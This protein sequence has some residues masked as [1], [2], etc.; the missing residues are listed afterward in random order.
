MPVYNPPEIFL[1]EAIESVLNQSY[2]H[3]EF[4]IA[5]DASPSLHIKHILEEYQ[6]QDSRIKVIFRTQNG[7]ISATSNSALELATGEFIGLLDH[8]DVLTPD[9]LYEVV[10]LLNQNPAADMIYSDED[11]LNEKGELTGHFFKPDWCPDSFLSRMYTCHFGVYRRSIIQ[12]I[13]GFRI[14]YEGSQDYD[15]VLR[16]TEKTDKIFH[17]PKI[18][19]HWRIHN[20]SAAGGTEAKPYAYEAAK[21]ALQDAIDRRGEPGI[22]KDVSIY[23]GHYLV[24]Y[25]ILDYKRV[26]III[27][28]RD[29]GEILN[30]CLESIFTLSIYPDYEVIVIDNGSTEEETQEI[31]EKWQEKEPT[32]FRYYALDIPFN[33]SKI[34]NYAVRQAT[35]DYLLLL[36]NDTEVIH[37]DWIDAM[38][39]QAQRRS[40][41]AVG[42]L[43]R[44]PDKIVQHAGVVVGIGHF[45]AHSHRMASETDPGYYGQVISISNYSAVTAACLMC[46]REV[47]E[48]V[49]GFDEQLAVAYNDVDFCLK[50]VEQGYRNIYLP[51]VV[52]YHYESKSRGYDTTPDKL[53]RFM[54]EVTIMRQRWQHY[55]DYD[56]CYNPNLTLSSSNYG[57]RQFAEVKI[58]DVS[59]KLDDQVLEN[60]SIDEP[61]IKIYTGIS[62]I[63]FK[64]WV[65]GQQEKVTA[66][67]IIG[68]HAQV[69]K[70]IP[71]N[72]SRPDV[73]IL[74]PENP[75][76]ELCGFDETVEITNLS[77][78]TE[79]LLQAVLN[80]RTYAKFGTV[81]LKIN[82]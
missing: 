37:P 81:K 28:T 68:N 41:G 53:E 10:S 74:H 70:E 27:P 20:S 4:C 55:V 48:Q 9:A 15:L 32:R 31:L 50:L 38:V 3:W 40:I 5:D 17:I 57:L 69:I 46:R 21:R 82:A 78:Q 42:A 14:G 62:E 43:L 35:G 71:A 22:V 36:N 24:R 80:E 2:P 63:R 56:P 59:L 1:R 26:S 25:K 45:A 8:D 73:A 29:L 79:L 47:F 7:H 77:N 66:V 11:K 33:F 34:N 30:R 75:H 49:G 65:L 18:L 58:S 54:Q 23:L 16:F 61:E 51:H 60:C 6:Q 52:L 67:Q 12:E 72:F 44:Y 76:S 19:Y 13:G 39:E 64:G